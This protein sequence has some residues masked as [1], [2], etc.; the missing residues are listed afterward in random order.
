MTRTRTNPR[1]SA[2][3]I[4]VSGK[5]P[6][7]RGDASIGIP[8]EHPLAMQ[9]GRASGIANRAIHICVIV[10]RATQPVRAPL[11]L[12][13]LQLMPPARR[14]AFSLVELMIA[15]GVLAIGIAMVAGLFP[16]AIKQTEISY[17]DAVGTIIAQNGLAMARATLNDFNIDI[18]GNIGDPL[19]V[20]VDDDN[21]HGTASGRTKLPAALR[22]YRDNP[23]LTAPTDK[24]FLVLGRKISSNEAQLVIVAY[25]KKNPSDNVTAVSIN[26]SS[27]SADAA[28]VS[29]NMPNARRLSP[30]ILADTGRY[31]IIEKIEQPDI[32]YLDHQKLD[33]LAG[34]AWVVVEAGQSGVSP[35]MA[36]V[37]A[38]VALP[39]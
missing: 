37:S 4:S 2:G 29:L 32:L 20:V 25:A 27:I 15:L 6:A 38:T 22:A 34:D 16:A 13:A 3:C 18:P 9:V 26:I 28:T 39:Q 1:P 14:A 23:D 10:A 21:T 5:P 8:L 12:H 11:G 31:A 19:Q 35:A 7:P 33:G 30:L 24:G 17:N 36:V